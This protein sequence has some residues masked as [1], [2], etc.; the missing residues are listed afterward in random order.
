MNPGHRVFWRD[1]FTYNLVGYPLSIK[2]DGP[3]NDCN[4]RII[5]HCIGKDNRVVEEQATIQ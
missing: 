4:E 5:K 3:A 2:R 1:A